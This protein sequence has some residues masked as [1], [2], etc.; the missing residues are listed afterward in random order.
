MFRGLTAFDLEGWEYPENMI[1]VG[2]WENHTAP[3]ATLL[4]RWGIEGGDLL[5]QLPEKSN[6]VAVLN[7]TNMELIR[8]YLAERSGREVLASVVEDLGPS[9]ADP[10]VDLCVYRFTYAE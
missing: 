6:M 10:S 1:Q 5:Q 2:G 8:T 3:W 9:S 4:E 7:P